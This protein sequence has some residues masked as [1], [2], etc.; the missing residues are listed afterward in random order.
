[1]CSTVGFWLLY[2]Q[3]SCLQRIPLPV[4][5]TVWSLA[6]MWILIRCALVCSSHDLFFLL[7]HISTLPVFFNA[8][9]SLS[10]V[11][12]F[13]LPTSGQFLGVFTMI[14]SL[15]VFIWWGETRFLIVCFHLSFSLYLMSLSFTFLILKMY[16][17]QAPIL[18]TL[19]SSS[20]KHRF[21]QLLMRD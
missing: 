16:S 5:G 19:V 20:A 11:V 18:T 3:A 21:I 14:C 2:P 9:C 15:V 13:V 4:M 12:E 6:Q 1:M 10:L 7:N 8:A 17:Q